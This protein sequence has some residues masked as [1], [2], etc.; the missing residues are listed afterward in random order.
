MLCTVL[1]LYTSCL[2]SLDPERDAGSASGQRSGDAEGPRYYLYRETRRAHPELAWIR[3]ENSRVP[4]GTRSRGFSASVRA[5]VP[6]AAASAFGFLFRCPFLYLYLH[7]NTL[8]ASTH[9][10]SVAQE[11]KSMHACLFSHGPRP[12]RGIT[13]VP[14]RTVGRARGRIRTVWR[15]AHTEDEHGT[16]PSP[17]GKC[18]APKPVETVSGGPPEGFTGIP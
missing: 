10:W 8:G 11:T 3:F 13:S 16:R 14:P 1:A 18:D 6:A 7:H 12:C 15:S 9:R 2:S 17:G 4:V 5:I